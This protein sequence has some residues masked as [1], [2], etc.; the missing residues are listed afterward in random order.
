MTIPVG[1]ALTL[2]LIVG[3]LAYA[4]GLWHGRLLAGRVP[5]DPPVAICGCGHHF[6]LHA[7]DG[8]GC[9]AE[10]QVVLSRGEPVSINYRV[11]Y[12]YEKSETRVC[13]C[14]RYVGPEPLPL[15]LP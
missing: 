9:V 2:G 5:P 6:A 4:A 12:K 1:L 14:P 11:V 7:E 13:A 10:R 15:V 3:M 8:G